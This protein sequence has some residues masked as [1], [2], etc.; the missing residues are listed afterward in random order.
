MATTAALVYADPNKMRYLVTYT[1]GGGTSVSISTTG[2]ATPD[3]LTDSQQGPLRALAKAFTDGFAGFAAG[4]L[5][6]DQA[7]ALWLS[8]WAG[9]DPAPGDPAGVNS[10]ITTAIC[11]LAKHISVANV[12]WTV[13]ANVDGGGNPILTVA[14]S[15]L[16]GTASSFYLDI[17]VL[18]AIG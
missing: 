4:A 11:R 17:E 1:G 13:D 8:D 16:S 5:N 9:A 7:R 18:E 15:G 6:Q 3:V 10:R 12:S 14:I 2:A